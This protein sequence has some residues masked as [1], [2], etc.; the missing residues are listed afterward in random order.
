MPARPGALVLGGTGF[1][2]RHVCEG[3]GDLGHEVVAAARRP[4][5]TPLA[6]RFQR[7]DLGT[8]PVR[9]TA[10]VL[11]ALRPAVVVNA[12]GSI[13]G[14][15]DP[16]MWDAVAAPTLRLL[17]ALDLLPEDHRPRLVHLG[18]VLEYGRVAPG[19]T[20]RAAV[21][22]RPT[23]AYGRAKLAATEAVLDR[24]RTGR[25]TG[26]VLRV[27]NLAGPG[28][29]EVSLLGRVAGR[30]ARPGPDGVARIELDPLLA[31]RD[32]VDVRDVAD[33][34]IAA[35]TSPLT[36][37]LVDLG[38]GESVPVRALVDLLVERSGVRA[39]ITERPGTGVRHSTEDWSKVDI[40]PA[41]RLLNWHPRRTL[42]ASVED[43]WHEFVQRPHTPDGKRSV[44]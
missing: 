23:S 4:P 6:G 7:L 19:T 13:W 16:E 43:F 18:S 9:E 10:A 32:Y 37:E 1:V 24:A 34:V 39:E 20:M 41:A 5:D 27:A 12:V 26:M 44:L 40:R 25:L 35:A 31:R 22:A 30:L 15:T 38:R 42:A 33:A 14:R 8:Q 11:A 28:S 17:D 36:G 21:T 2:G 3:L 29:P